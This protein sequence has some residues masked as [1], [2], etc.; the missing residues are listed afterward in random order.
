[1]ADDIML[2][3]GNLNWT[4]VP[5]GISIAEALATAQSKGEPVRGRVITG[6]SGTAGNGDGIQRAIDYW[7]AL[8]GTVTVSPGY[9]AIISD[10]AIRGFRVLEAARE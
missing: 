5:D 2:T 1:M 6:I 3:S 9:E 7:I 10:G 4:N 8:D